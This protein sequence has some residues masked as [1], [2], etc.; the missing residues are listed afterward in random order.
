V[1]GSIVHHQDQALVRI[2][3][4]G[5]VFQKGNEG[6]AILLEDVE[7]GQMTTVPVIGAQDMAV[8]RYAGSRD[9]L[10]LTA[11]H[12]AAAQ[13]RMQTQ[14]RF[15]QEEELESGAGTVG[16]VFLTSP[17][18]AAP[19]AGPARLAGRL[20]RVSVVATRSPACSTAHGSACS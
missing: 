2:D 11:F 5:Q 18:P 12:P 16:H 3:G 20:S 1:V 8:Q 7:P 10:A 13:R 9:E 19:P 15:V 17:V 4:E 6:L 14:G